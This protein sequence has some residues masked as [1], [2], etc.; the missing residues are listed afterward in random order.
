M[1]KIGRALLPCLLEISGLRGDSAE[2]A[3]SISNVTM[4]VKKLIYGVAANFC[5][6]VPGGA[7]S[8]FPLGAEA[9]RVGGGP[10]GARPMKSKV[11]KPK[12]TRNEG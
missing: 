8:I 4:N 1:E 11:N 6:D 5:D 9:L 12:T 10:G 7:R 2:V 3:L